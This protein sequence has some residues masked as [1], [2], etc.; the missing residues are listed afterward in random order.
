MCRFLV[1]LFFIQT[2]TA[3]AE[4]LD[5]VFEKTKFSLNQQSLEAY[6]ADDESKRERGLMFVE[7]LPENT[8]MLFIFNDERELG[9]WMKN[10]LIPLSIGFFDKAGRLVDIQEMKVAS[11]MVSQAVPSYRSR[12]NAQFALEMNSGW[13]AKRK[14]KVGARLK[15]AG[16]VKSPLINQ[17]ALA[18]KTPTRQ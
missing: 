16:K 13:F 6:V 11:S 15:L 12:T 8:G 2:M 5:D 10:T 17:S 7:R 1:S 14:V 4:G 3:T 9:F 18:V